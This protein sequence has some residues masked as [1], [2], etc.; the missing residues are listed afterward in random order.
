M[1]NEIKMDKI[2]TYYSPENP[3]PNNNQSV[4]ETVKQADVSV[5]NQLN[6]MVKLINTYQ[7]PVSAA[8]LGEIKYQIQQGQYQVNFDKL[9]EKL[10]NNGILG[11]GD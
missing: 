5:T 4:T 11:L 2:N 10:L 7:E 3:S 1:V 8:A 9:S 6:D